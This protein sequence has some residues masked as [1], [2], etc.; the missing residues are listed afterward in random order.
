MSVIMK[1]KCVS[2]EEAVGSHWNPDTKSHDPATLY[3][4]RFAFVSGSE[5][6]ENEAFWS[7][8]PS[9]QFSLQ[10]VLQDAF[11][12]SEYYYLRAEPVEG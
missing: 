11:K 5:S 8:T 2:R 10:T 4:Y 9:G 7:A 12:L 6:P 3:S 1:V